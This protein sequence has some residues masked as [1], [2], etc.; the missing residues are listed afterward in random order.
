MGGSD[1]SPG[2]VRLCPLP[3]PACICGVASTWHHTALGLG[4]PLL[5]CHPR[6]RLLLGCSWA[7]W[8]FG[9]PALSCASEAGES[10]SSCGSLHSAT[11]SEGAGAVPLGLEESWGFALNLTR[12]ETKG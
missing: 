12:H 9:I 4:K 1:V 5:W 8:P 11:G 6:G 2:K 10:H 7:S 3:Q